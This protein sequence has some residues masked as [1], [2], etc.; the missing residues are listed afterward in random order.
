[1]VIYGRFGDEVT[2]VRR[3]TLADVKALDNRKPDK[4]DRDIVELGG[5]V[6]V[7][8]DDGVERLYHLAFLRADGG[9]AEIDTAIAVAT[10]ESV[11]AESEET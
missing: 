7:R 1:V 2:V 6:V 10:A 8:Q 11:L 3:G 9:I 5:Y 4:R